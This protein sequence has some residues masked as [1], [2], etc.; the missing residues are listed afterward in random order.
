MRVFSIFA[1]TLFAA[2]SAQA[3]TAE[4]VHTCKAAVADAV[5]KDFDAPTITYEKISGASLKKITFTVAD[6][7]REEVVVCKIKRGRV[8]SVDR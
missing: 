7:D 4:D 6:G 1:L 2:T 8:V 3:G 5:A